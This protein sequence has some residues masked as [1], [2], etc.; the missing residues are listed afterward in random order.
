MAETE[1]SAAH[2]YRTTQEFL[3]TRARTIAKKREEL[4]TEAMRK[5]KYGL[6]GPKLTREEATRYV[7]NSGFLISAWDEV[8]L[9]GANRANHIRALR[10]LAMLN[11]NGLMTLT[12]KDA[13]VLSTLVPSTQRTE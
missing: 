4:V 3:D 13:S 8:L 6:F 12:H 10:D 1:V 7:Q 2:V 5:R 11:P 9:C